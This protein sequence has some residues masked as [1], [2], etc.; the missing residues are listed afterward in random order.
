MEVPVAAGFGLRQHRLESL[1]WQGS[2]PIESG[3]LKDPGE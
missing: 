3:S 2:F 1:C